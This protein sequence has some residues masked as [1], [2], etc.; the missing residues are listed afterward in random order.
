LL[1]AHPRSLLPARER[2]RGLR[3]RAR[4]RLMVDRRLIYHFDVVT[5]LLMLTIIAIGTA[6]V[7]SASW[8]PHSA[9]ASTFAWRQAMWATIG[10]CAT[11]AMV[12]F[13]YRKLERWAYVAYAGGL[14]LLLAVPL[15]GTVTNGSR[16]WIDLGA[17]SVQ[18][19]E[20]MKLAL[21]IVLARYFHRKMRP[22]GLRLRDLVVP[23]LLSL[24]PVLLILAQPDLGT[25]G[26]FCFVI[27]SMVVLAGPSPRTWA[28]I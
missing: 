5:M 3:R 23:V 10:T 22:E 9:R 8:D 24:P 17:F 4:M 7:Y 13:D 2:D 20:M 18:P 28:I 19:S 11:I 27:A 14:A 6:S 21:I 15:F 25:A 1:R 26:V 12:C 16:R